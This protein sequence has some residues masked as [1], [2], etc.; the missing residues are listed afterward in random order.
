MTFRSLIICA[1]A[2]LVPSLAVAQP[3][4]TA[5]GRTQVEGIAAI[6]N[7]EPISF[8]DVRQRATL[9]MMGIG[10]QPSPELQRQLLSQ[11]LEQLIDERLQIQEAAEYEVEVP[12]DEIAAAI[13]DMAAQ[14]NLTRD[15][16]YNE[17]K[18]IGINPASLEQQM[19]AEIAW[20]RIMGGLYGSRIRISPNQIDDQI[21][22]L[23]RNASETQYQ[24]SEIFLYTADETEK[25]QAKAAA[26]SL[27]DQLRQGAPFQLA[28]QR[29]SSAPTAATGGDMGWITVN[30][31]D[32]P[33]R[34]ALEALPGLGITEPIEV[35]NGIYLL[36]LRS[37]REPADQTP[38]VELRQLIA[39]NN[40]EETLTQALGQI[41]N[42][43]EGIDEVAEANTDLTAVSLGQIK[44]T[45]LNSEMQARVSATAVG[46]GS[47]PYTASAGVASIFVCS[48]AADGTGLP[49]RDQIENTL[50]GRQLGMVS[51][52]ALRDLKREATIIRR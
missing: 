19:R 45:D 9:L 14:S 8:S 49:S 38:L 31:L 46:A 23:Q 27:L 16:L 22:R 26:V 13:G 52:R 43:C 39:T 7:D 2:M 51:E 30:T 10:Q 48:R 37:K 50:Y 5:D 15:A 21:A 29:F 3:A 28:A 25:E 32:A 40:S 44:E 12:A 33:L 24:V 42:G 4:T 18:T 20:R 17:L 6:V 36:A 35:E 34:E 1:A 47:A 11:A 41:Q